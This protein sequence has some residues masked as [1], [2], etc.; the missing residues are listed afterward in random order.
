MKPD[1]NDLLALAGV[2][3]ATA[4]IACYSWPAALI[5]LGV[6]LALAGVLPRLPR[7]ERR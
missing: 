4:G 7:K 5:A 6:V 3:L 2:A 1:A